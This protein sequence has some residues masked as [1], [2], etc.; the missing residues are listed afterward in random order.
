L[1]ERKEGRKEGRKDS[2]LSSLDRPSMF[3]PFDQVLEF[4]YGLNICVLLL[5]Y[6][7]ELNIFEY[8]VLEYSYQ[9]NI[10]HW[11]VPTD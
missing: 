11:N 3:S 9:L 7:Y 2:S 5:L 10:F 8:F 6:P 4:P 1:E